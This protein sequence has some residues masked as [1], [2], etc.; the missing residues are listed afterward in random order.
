M[1]WTRGAPEVN[2]KT[3]KV[4]VI[5][6]LLMLQMLKKE[7][8]RLSYQSDEVYLRYSKRDDA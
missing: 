5:T 8:S 2:D 6:A 7:L 4:H 3:I 1:S